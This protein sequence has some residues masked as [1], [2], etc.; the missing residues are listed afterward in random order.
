MR[1]TEYFLITN[2]C[3]GVKMDE[4]KKK[5]IELNEKFYR[6][7]EKGDMSLMEDIWLVDNNVKCI[8]PGWPLI[9]GWDEIKESW[10]K[11]FE[12]G[13]LSSVEID[14]TFVEVGEKAA[15]VNCIEK[16]SHTIGEQVVITMAQTTN[17]FE[18]RDS[19]WY[20]VLHH[21]SP[22]PVPRSENLSE[23]LQ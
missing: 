1:L 23:T 21:A 2:Y 4:A 18:K 7:L 19:R 6:A 13:E 15:W 10:E 12:A 20:L 3:N 14:D 16:L 8:H 9:T 11:I 17:I 22:M 5:L